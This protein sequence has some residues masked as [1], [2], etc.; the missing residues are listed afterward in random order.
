RA[1]GHTEVVHGDGAGLHAT[2]D[3][4]GGRP[5]GAPHRAREAVGRVVGDRYGFV[6]RFV[7]EH[8]Q[9]RPEDLL[10]GDGHVVGHVGEH[11]GLD[12]VAVTDVGT[13]SAGGD[14]CALVL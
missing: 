8:R 13:A 14:P 2:S 6:D 4:G 5:V 3:V 7:R 1:E 12:E 9:H 11:G 10:A